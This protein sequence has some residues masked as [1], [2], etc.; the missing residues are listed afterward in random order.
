MSNIVSIVYFLFYFLKGSIVNRFFLIIVDCS[1]F[2][3]I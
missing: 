2:N 1:Y 3:G